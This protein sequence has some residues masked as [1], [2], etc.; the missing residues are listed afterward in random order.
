VLDCFLLVAIVKFT[1]KGI[2]K[3]AEEI[4]AALNIMPTTMIRHLAAIC[5]NFNY[6]ILQI[7]S[8]ARVMFGVS[9]P[10]K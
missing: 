8:Q 4:P 6:L 10:E 7:T 9:Q 5:E 3:P 1:L 2:R